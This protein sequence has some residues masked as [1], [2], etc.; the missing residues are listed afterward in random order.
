MWQRRGESADQLG[1]MRSTCPVRADSP[2][3]E[4]CQPE[5]EGMRDRRR[6]EGGSREGDQEEEREG[7]KEKRDCENEE[8]AK[9]REE[10]RQRN[11]RYPQH[12]NC[13]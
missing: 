3:T 7:Q 12:L 8:D 4:V 5:K 9:K 11:E 6:K 2:L 10:E 13:V 1:E